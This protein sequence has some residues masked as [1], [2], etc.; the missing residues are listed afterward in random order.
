MGRVLMI[1]LAIQLHQYH[2]NSNWCPVSLIL[3]SDWLVCSL[4]NKPYGQFIHLE[5]LALTVHAC[6]CTGL[7]Y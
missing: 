1:L 5:A 2:Y 4:S 7:Q 3:V 6:Y